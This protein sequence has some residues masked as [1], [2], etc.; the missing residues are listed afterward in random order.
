MDQQA[1]CNKFIQNVSLAFPKA[2]VK[3]IPWKSIG[4]RPTILVEFASSK[5][6][7]F[8]IIHNDPLHM[9]LLVEGSDAEGWVIDGP[10]YPQRALRAVGASFRKLKG[11]TEAEVMDKL[12][13]WFEKNV[14][15]IN[16]ATPE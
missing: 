9:R 4:D 15:N 8:N 13:N 6:W 5:T 3:A 2:H 12:E 14:A 11:K 1:I 10:L 7:N 16:A